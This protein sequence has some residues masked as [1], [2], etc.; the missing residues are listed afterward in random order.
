MSVP[1]RNDPDKWF[2][3][4]RQVEAQIAC[5]SCPLFDACAAF[6][7]SGDCDPRWGAVAAKTPRER[8]NEAGIKHRHMKWSIGVTE[9]KS[10]V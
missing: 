10:V 5:V 9:E 6:A 3:E 8:M 1:C 4:K 7:E 2:D